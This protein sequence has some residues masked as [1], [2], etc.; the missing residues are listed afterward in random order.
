MA[1]DDFKVAS[2]LVLNNNTTP[3]EVKVIFSI[4]DADN[5][6]A[7]DLKD[8]DSVVRDQTLIQVHPAPPQ[9]STR[10][11]LPNTA[12]PSRRSRARRGTTPK[13][14]S[15]TSASAPS[16]AALARRP[17]SQLTSSRRGCRISA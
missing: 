2:Q 7:I 12:P 6:G 14:R 3:L 9:R 16:P 8:F 13:S 10:S 17:F 5:D 1:T 4:F 11:A 15:S